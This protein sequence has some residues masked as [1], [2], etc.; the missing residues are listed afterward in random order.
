M[1]NCWFIVK[2]FKRRQEGILPHLPQTL[3]PPPS[4]PDGQEMVEGD[5]ADAPSCAHQ[6]CDTSHASWVRARCGTTCG[7]TNVLVLRARPGVLCSLLREL[8]LGRPLPRRRRQ[9]HP[10]D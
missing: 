2:S 3:T 1:G 8:P 7:S 4:F 6:D 5:T 9:L 10:S